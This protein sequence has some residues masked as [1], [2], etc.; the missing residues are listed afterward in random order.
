MCG[1]FMNEWTCPNCGRT[2][3]TGNFCDICATSMPFVETTNPN[4]RLSDMEKAIQSYVKP[5]GDIGVYQLVYEDER[6]EVKYLSYYDAIYIRDKEGCGSAYYNNEDGYYCSMFQIHPDGKTVINISNSQDKKIYVKDP[7]TIGDFNS[8]MAVIDVDGNFY[9]LSSDI[10]PKTASPFFYVTKKINYQEGSTTHYDLDG[11]YTKEIGNKIEYCDNNGKMYRVD[12]RINGNHIIST[13]NTDDG[14]IYLSNSRV[15][16]FDNKENYSGEKVIGNYKIDDE[17]NYVVI[18]L[19][20]NTTIYDNRGIKVKYIDLFGN[21]TIYNNGKEIKY[22]DANGNIYDFD[23]STMIATKN[24]KKT[25]SMINHIEYDEE[26]YSTVLKSLNTIRD[27]YKETIKN[28]C[29]NIEIAVGGFPDSYSVGEISSIA[30]GIEGHIDLVSS[31]SEMT[32]YSLLAYQS[33]DESLKEGLYLL[34][35]SLFGENEIN[36]AQNFK[37]SIKDTIEDRDN[38]SIIEYKEST[39]FKVLLENAFVDST[40]IDESGNK[41]YLNKNKIVL[42]V[43]GNNIKI[44]YG[45]EIFSVTS[46]EDNIIILKDSNGKALDIFGDYNINSFQYGAAQQHVICSYFNPNVVSFD[47]L[48]VDNV[49]NSYFPNS[50]LEEKVALLDEIASSGCGDTSLV[51]FVFK[52]YEGREKE[53]YNTFGYPMYNISLDGGNLTVDY[54]YEPLIVD[55]SCHH[56]LRQVDNTNSI[57]ETTMNVNGNIDETIIESIKY[58]N[59]NY[60]VEFNRSPNEISYIHCSGYSLYNMDGT[61]FDIPSGGHAMT[62]VE[63]LDDG[64][65]IVST[66]GNKF[67]FDSNSDDSRDFTRRIFFQEE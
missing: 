67:I 8:N 43:E 32:N 51:N 6:F 52:E 47:N 63:K 20:E 48:Y 26:S 45:G 41:W 19:M 9:N 3:L 21:T 44:N 64:K 28:R 18:D 55:I 24:G 39:N 15:V 29:S 57:A 17:G 2:G 4:S 53:F 65:Y 16:K 59:N 34:I 23:K 49:L 33:C 40:Y 30:N 66:W 11:N 46:N 14:A 31:L 61:S 60:G 22:I 62:G 35:N 10:N 56:N 5:D 42:G 37:N 36:I 25:Y 38:D 58:L 27:S 50:N 13:I 7:M 12:E 1:D 54:N